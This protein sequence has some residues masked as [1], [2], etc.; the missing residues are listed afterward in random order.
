MASEDIDYGEVIHHFYAGR[1]YGVVGPNYED[2]NW[3]DTELEKPSQAELAEKWETIKEKVTL[4]RIYEQR[5]TPGEYPA[6]DE[7]IVA[8]WKKV[9][10]GNDDLAAELQAKREET[11]AKYPKPE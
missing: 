7:L 10:E 11:K 8:L 3:F 1:Q 2:I 5:Q 6:R 9:M 4:Q